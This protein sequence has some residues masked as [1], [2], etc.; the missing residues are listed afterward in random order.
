MEMWIARDKD[1]ELYLYI[2]KPDRNE[3]R[4]FK[5]PF[6][7]IQK[8]YFPSL[9]W[10]NSPQKVTVELAEVVHG[11]LGTELSQ[12]ECVQL[13]TPANPILSRGLH[14]FDLSVRA[15]H[16]LESADI[17]TVGELVKWNRSDLLKLRNFGLHTLREIEDFLTDHQLTF[18]MKV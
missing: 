4:F 11:H 10:E 9:T 14:E 18:G 5:Y 16:C 12:C 13:N 17:H 8:K 1:G 15:M 3:Q 6:V 2:D 7:E